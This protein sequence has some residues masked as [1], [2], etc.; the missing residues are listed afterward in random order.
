[1][2][3]AFVIRGRFS[4]F[5]GGLRYTRAAFVIRG[6]FSLFGG[7]F[8][9]SRGMVPVIF[10][11]LRA[12]P[13]TL[14]RMVLYSRRCPLLTTPQGGVGSAALH[15]ACSFEQQARI[16]CHVFGNIVFV[17]CWRAAA[18][19]LQ[20]CTNAFPLTPPLHWIPNIP[21][22]LSNA[23]KAFLSSPDRPLSKNTVCFFK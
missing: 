5:E 12:W 9:Y 23:N 18:S 7:G 3:A 14:F 22:F 20:V 16:Y 13:T 17:V 11:Y 6:R 4:L 8:R 15:Q 1:M 19:H 21:A 10:V 2:R